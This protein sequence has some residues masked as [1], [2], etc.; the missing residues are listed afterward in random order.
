[1]IQTISNKQLIEDVHNYDVILFGMGINNSMNKGLAYD[2]ALNFPEVH[3]NENL[4]GYGDT[5]KYGTV[6]E[7]LTEDGVRFCSCYCYNIGLNR[8]NNGVFID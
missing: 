7:T 3:T 5:R 8:K 2:I 4:T 1:M 6:G